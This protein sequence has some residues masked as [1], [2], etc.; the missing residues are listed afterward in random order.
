MGE[1]SLTFV[2]Y[3]VDLLLKNMVNFWENQI[4]EHKAFLPFAFHMKAAFS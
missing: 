3:N 2:S 1:G 4:K